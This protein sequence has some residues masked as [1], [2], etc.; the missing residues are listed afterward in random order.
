MD[1]KALEPSSGP[2]TQLGSRP[3]G[4]T[5]PQSHPHLCNLIAVAGCLAAVSGTWFSP[6]PIW[7]AL[8]AWGSVGLATWLPQWWQLG[9]VWEPGP[10]GAAN[11]DLPLLN[12]DWDLGGWKL[13]LRTLPFLVRVENNIRLVEIYKNIIAWPWPDF[14]N[15]RSDTKKFATTSHAPP[16]HLL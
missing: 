4:S 3:W 8:G 6:H 13:C 12:Q 16:S 15:K 9:R 1:S 14:K 5:E 2:Y 10:E 11:W 7:V